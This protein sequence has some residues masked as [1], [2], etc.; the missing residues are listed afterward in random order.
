MYTYDQVRSASL[1]YFDGDEL[2][3]EVFASKYALQD[4]QGNFYELTPEDMHRRLAREFARIESKYPNPLSEDEIFGYLA[5]WTIVPQG[6]P[7]S[8]IG[9][10]FQIQSLSNCFV[11]QPSSDSYGG[12]CRTDEEQVQIM[13][14]RGG[15]GHDISA[16]RPKGMPAAN[17]ARTT[18]G[19]GVFMQRFSNTTREVAQGGRRGALM[20]SI[21]C[22]HPEVDTFI[23]IKK[24]RKKVTGANVSVRVTDEFMHAAM[25]GT[26]YE[27]RWPVDS[28]SPVVK[29]SVPAKE[30]WSKLMQA[31]W[32]CAEPGVLFWD[33]IIRESPADCYADE[34]YR[35]S[36]TNPCGELPLNPYDSCRL[37][38][39]NLFKFV[40]DPFGE[41]PFFDFKEFK[42]NAYV[43]QRL[44]DD[45][46]DLELEMIDKIIDKIRRDPE[47]DSEKLRELDLWN[48]IK[49]TTSNA[50]RTGL[51]ITALGDA[52]AA[53]GIRYGSDDSI[54]FTE[55]IY[56]DLAIASYVSSITM[57]KE[58]GSFPIWNLEKEKDHP[59][60]N[61]VLDAAAPLNTGIKQTYKLFGRRNI[62]NLTTSPA[63]TVSVETQTTSGGEPA[64]YLR[65]TRRKKITSSDLNARVDFVDELGDRWQEYE[66]FH[67]G[68]LLWAEING[69]DPIKDEKESPYYGCTATQIDWVSK[70]RMQAA[71]QRW[72]DHSISNT[73]NLPKDATVDDVRKVYETGWALG[74]KGVTVY[75]EGSR[76]GVMVSSDDTEK[77]A[78]ATPTIQDSKAPERPPR[79]PCDI[80]MVK[81]KGKPHLVLVGLLGGRPYEVF[82]GS[83]AK[84]DLSK[85]QRSGFL[86]RTETKGGSRYDLEIPEKDGQQDFYLDIVDLFDNPDHGAFT[87]TISTVLR[88]GVPVH[89]LVEQLRK[90][91]HAD[92]WSFSSVIAR[93]LG[94]GYV[95]DGTKSVGQKCSDCGSKNLSYQ[96][97]CA[98]CLDCGGSKC[99]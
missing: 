84:F 28:V 58:R 24:D 57:A 44:M 99:S 9:N 66:V 77:S 76:S 25:S 47:D 33:T 67:H 23:D 7:M 45:L 21:S 69:K 70:I 29:R 19:I 41:N 26:D 86:L 39:M 50:R 12:I 5:D 38:L 37:I 40:E 68:H 3:A 63:G 51:G 36:S 64:I 31:A 90:D 81:L 88:H 78:N 93:V 59:F 82:F 20:L 4:L 43:A 35:T 52:L 6:G 11:I 96:Q 16:I 60:I 72:V 18:D 87:R 49:L 27:Q 2:A 62:A 8:G 71:A 65:Y 83:A 22:H 91:K 10:P 85:D 97:G 46:V 30:V 79:L 17:A 94:K 1:E 80:H 53:R 61:R 56:K 74:C 75:R 13:K 34:G 92:L 15:V 55:E 95:A 89:Q 32:D 48:K 73:T 98:T 42:R 54:E 14:R